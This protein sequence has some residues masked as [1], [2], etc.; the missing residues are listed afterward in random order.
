ML[1]LITFC[2]SISWT[3]NVKMSCRKCPP[4]QYEHWMG[5]FWWTMKKLCL[6]QV[7]VDFSTVQKWKLLHLDDFWAILVES[8]SRLDQM[9]I[10]AS[11]WDV[12]QKFWLLTAKWPFYPLVDCEAIRA[13]DCA[14]WPCEPWN[15][16]CRCLTMCMSIWDLIDPLKTSTSLQEPKP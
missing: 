1:K 13:F 10:V 2:E 4:L 12:D 5:F 15:L 6:G 3:W 9:M 8:W 16:A 7:T 11:K 14:T